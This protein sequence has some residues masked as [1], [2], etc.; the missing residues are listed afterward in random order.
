[1]PKSFSLFSRVL[2]LPSENWSDFAD[3]WFCHDHGNNG[4]AKQ[5]RKLLPG[6]KECFVAE[7]YVL[8]ARQ[9]VNEGNVKVT[10]SGTVVCRRCGRQLGITIATDKSKKDK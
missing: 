5:Q 10:K 3:M 8:V 2:P 6:L 9:Y 1:M 4:V 7:T